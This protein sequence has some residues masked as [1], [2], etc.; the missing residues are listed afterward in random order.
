MTKRLWIRAYLDFASR[1]SNA[2]V[3]CTLMLAV[4]CV[5]IS[6]RIRLDPDLESLLPRKTETFRALKETNARFGSADMF[7]IAIVMKDPEAVARIQDGID[8]ALRKDWPDVV[9]SQK[10]RDNGFFEEHAL[11]YLPTAYLKDIL[12]KLRRVEMDLGN[13]TPLVE[14]LLDED[15]PAS[16]KGE[17]YTS[18]SPDSSDSYATP[19]PTAVGHRRS[20]RS[21]PRRTEQRSP[22]G[23][24]HTMPV[25][26]LDDV[27]AARELDLAY[28]PPAP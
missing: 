17:M 21:C 7:T 15:P 28:W 18:H 14:N 3:A 1:R 27:R 24:P 5:L 2:V 22:R 9:Y 23:A 4:A 25:R 6:L 16:G 11:L 12:E 13:R 8:S 26:R 20:L 19:A 10:E